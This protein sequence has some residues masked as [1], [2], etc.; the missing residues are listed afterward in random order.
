MSNAAL[1]ALE[2]LYVNV[3]PEYPFGVRDWELVKESLERAERERDA[4]N[5]KHL[6]LWR[7]W[8]DAEAR[9]QKAEAEKG[10]YQMALEMIRDKRSED[11]SALITGREAEAIAFAAL[12][13]REWEATLADGLDDE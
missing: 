9:A 8:Q 6:V 5:E 3:R 11:G 4:G 12:E 1:D 13:G 10:I 2:R 7:R